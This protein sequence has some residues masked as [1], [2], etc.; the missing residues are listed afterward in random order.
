MKTIDIKKYV[1]SVCALYIVEIYRISLCIGTAVDGTELVRLCFSKIYYEDGSMDFMAMSAFVFWHLI[2]LLTFGTYF[3][4]RIMKNADI[5]FTRSKNRYKLLLKNLVYVCVHMLLSMVVMLFPFFAV[6]MIRDF[7]VGT[8]FAYILRLFM[9]M[10]EIVVIA[11]VLSLHMDA[12]YS[13]LFS[14]CF[15]VF[16]ALLRRNGAFSKMVPVSLILAME[17]EEYLNLFIINIIY[18]SI[19]IIFAVSINRKEVF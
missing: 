13:I 14:I 3:E 11:N 12:V 16:C 9:Y 2:V 1:I 19:I 15:A 18:L 4:D 17:H 6:C 10:V 7:K 8:D 5:L